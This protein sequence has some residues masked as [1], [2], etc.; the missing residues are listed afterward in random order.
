MCVRGPHLQLAQLSD[1]V[2]ILVVSVLCSLVFKL[3]VFR[4]IAFC[5]SQHYK[6]AILQ[7]E[8]LR[9]CVYI[10]RT[11]LSRGAHVNLE[12]HR[13]VDFPQSQVMSIR[14]KKVCPQCDA[15]LHARKLACPCGQLITTLTSP[16]YL[17]SM[18]SFMCNI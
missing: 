13:V 2:D 14:L 15:T 6:S 7:T 16:I 9:A 17:T 12:A 10:Q 5:Y 3:G 18:A 11:R 4:T 8:F 1:K